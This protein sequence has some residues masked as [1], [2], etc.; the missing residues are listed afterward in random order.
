MIWYMKA[1]CEDNTEA[2]KE[3]LAS[4]RAKLRQ[5]HPAGGAATT[6]E[7]PM[8]G[9]TGKPYGGGTGGPVS[10]SEDNPAKAD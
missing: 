9:P 5:Q 3:A 10:P 4:A 7:G 6:D 1:A 2:L 8:G